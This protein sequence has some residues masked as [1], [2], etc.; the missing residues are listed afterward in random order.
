MKLFVIVFLCLRFDLYAQYEFTND[1][2]LNSVDFLN[3]IEDFKN[4]AKNDIQNNAPKLFFTS[5]LMV[6]KKENDNEFQKH[7][8]VNYYDFGCVSPKKNLLKAYNFEVFKFLSDKFGNTWLK[9]VRKDAIGL[10][11]YKMSLEKFKISCSITYLPSFKEIFEKE[12]IPK[13][14][15]LLITDFVL[16]DS[17]IIHLTDDDLKLF[18]QI[19]EKRNFENK[20]IYNVPSEILNEILQTK[21]I[22][23]NLIEVS[24]TELSVSDLLSGTIDGAPFTLKLETKNQK[25]NSFKGNLSSLPLINK[26]DEYYLFYSI[27]NKVPF[28]DKIN[29]GAYF[30]KEN[31]YSLIIRFL[32][33]K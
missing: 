26:L 31:L 1:E 9:T 2:T 30:A 28:C 14:K 12:K 23:L 11:E 16:Q 13:I 7:F 18:K 6:I 10:D 24:N 17:M 22:H 25:V 5:G 19:V 29:F 20:K 8:K 33:Y 15:S 4:F 3:T 21:I 27:Y 32:S